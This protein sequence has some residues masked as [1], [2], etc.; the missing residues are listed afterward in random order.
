V[1][2]STSRPATVLELLAKG[3]G[4]RLH[5]F[6]ERVS[7]SQLAETLVGLANADG[8]VILLG[9]AP[10]SSRIQGVRDAAQ[11]IDLIFQAALLAD[12]PLI[13]PLPQ[14]D[15]VDGAIVVR[16]TV[17]M[18]LPQVYNLDGRYLGRRGT[19]TTP[20]SPPELRQ[21]LMERGV[22]Q[23]ESQIPPN[24]SQDDLDPE[25]LSAYITSLDLPENEPIEAVLARRGCLRFE[26]GKLRPTYAALLLF[27]K[28]PQ[29]WLPSAT[30][31]AARFPGVTFSDEFIK[32]NI[33]GT[34]PDQLRQTEVFVRDQLRSVAR[35]IGLERQETPEYP[36]AAVREL[37]VNAIAHRDYNQQGD[38]VHLHIF[39]DRLEIHSPGALPGPVNLGNL[40]DARFSRN[41]V[42][43]Q[44]LSDLGFVE[45]L[46]YGL[47]RVVGTMRQFNLPDP[48]FLEVGGSFRVALR[49]AV[50][51]TFAAQITG[52]E[53]QQPDISKFNHL[54]LNFRQ[55][56]ALGH[57]TIRGRINNRTY[58]SLC[59]DVSAETIRRDLA[60]LVKKGVLIKVGDKKSTYY[61]LK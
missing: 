40:L 45:R 48:E 14:T 3:M 55:E 8:G 51:G 50:A 15:T 26:A 52:L 30:V 12:P 7:V 56:T 6:P 57:I 49:N 4:S 38:G 37:L 18:G 25:Q 39:A 43:A 17:P 60:D 2:N 32:H 24:V 13:L 16:V 29:Q 10:R 36:L 34:L 27:G 42:I 46:G 9:V 53:S 58:Q 59:P 31:L 33:R 44:V 20:F 41:P 54:L 28:E 61:I 22:L 23:F 47:N 11:V 35:I 1:D 19:Q 5:W 21:R